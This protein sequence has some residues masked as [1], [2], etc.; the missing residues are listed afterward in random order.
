MPI[1]L[2]S[3]VVTLLGSIPS[4]SSGLVTIGPLTIHYYGAAI[5]LGVLAAV[6]LA[7]KRWKA[8]GGDPDDISNLALLCVPVGLIGTRIYHVI[9]DYQKLYCGP[10][11]CPKSLWPGAFEI[12]DGGLG[13][14]GG[15]AAGVIAGLI[16][17]RVKG[18]NVKVGYDSVAPAIPLAQ[19]IG[20]WGN[21][22][23][24][25]LFGRPTSLPWGLEIDPL[26]RPERYASS[27]TFHPTF[28]YESLW[29]LGVVAVILAVDRRGRVKAGK[30][31]P[32]Y[33]GG[34]F[35]GRMWVEEMRSD[36]AA[37][38]GPFRWNFLLSVI[39]IVV[40][41]IWFFWGGALRS[42]GEAYPPAYVDGHRFAAGPD[43]LGSGA[44]GSG[45]QVDDG[46]GERGPDL[47]GP[48]P[49]PTPTQADDAEVAVGVEPPEGSGGTEVPD[50][51][52]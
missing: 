14:P 18:M 1:A 19:A 3:S 23:N 38:V 28:L 11:N 36:N 49:E 7:R 43:Q 45:D 50:G 12:W 29:N 33:L 16:F 22:F 41:L 35:L 31:F 27:P 8:R 21:W 44:M 4:P 34:Y 24:Q 5:A 10:P 2:S 13:I 25:E 9:T 32:I 40:S 6:W 42:P 17:A 15:I 52:R 39:M 37:M 48:G 30:L 26:H 46:V 20:R 51:P 47:E